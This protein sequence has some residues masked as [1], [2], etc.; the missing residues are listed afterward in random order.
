[1]SRPGQ[2]YLV[3]A[4]GKS[5][6][7]SAHVYSTEAEAAQM[8]DRFKWGGSSKVA[9]GKL[10]TRSTV[11]AVVSEYRRR[12]VAPLEG[13]HD[14]RVRRNP[15][16]AQ[17]VLWQSGWSHTYPSGVWVGLERLPV[18]GFSSSGVKLQVG[19]PENAGK[20]AGKRPG[21]YTLG[22]FDSEEEA[23]SEA[24]KWHSKVFGGGK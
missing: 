23:R 15:R 9:F 20:V 2:P 21:R 7:V 11:D 6:E 13:V 17:P 16:K 24:N 22:S 18:T 1:M 10:P 8:Y 12:W 19:I 5:G 4:L 14:H 3:V